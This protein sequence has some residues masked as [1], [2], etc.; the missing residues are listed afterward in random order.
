MEP[1]VFIADHLA[2]VISR[3]VTRAL[4]VHSQENGMKKSINFQLA[5]YSTSDHIQPYF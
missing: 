5:A 3:N 4:E 2:E 1:L